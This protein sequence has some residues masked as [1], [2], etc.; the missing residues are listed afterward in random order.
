MVAA[1]EFAFAAAICA[2]FLESGEIHYG[3][4]DFSCPYFSRDVRPDHY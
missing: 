1:V 4:T 3:I 2:N